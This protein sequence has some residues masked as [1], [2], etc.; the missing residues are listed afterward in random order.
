MGYVRDWPG[1]HR[2]RRTLCGVAV[3]LIYYYSLWTPGSS[4]P[5]LFYYTISFCFLW[6]SPFHSSCESSC[7]LLHQASTYSSPSFHVGMQ[8]SSK[9]NYFPVC[10]PHQLLSVYSV[11]Y[12]VGPFWAD[13]VHVINNKHN[14]S[15]ADH[16]SGFMLIPTWSEF[17]LT[18]LIRWNW[19]E[20]RV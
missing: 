8:V 3:Y 7:C 12:D 6:L 1:K 14:W 18:W 20:L 19:W 4:T 10:L 11:G 13:V 2:H 16:V 15:N 9:S 17:I 5:S